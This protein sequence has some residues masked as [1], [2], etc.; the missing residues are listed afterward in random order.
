[1]SYTKPGKPVFFS[2]IR[3]QRFWAPPAGYLPAFCDGGLRFDSTP[4]TKKWDE[5]SAWVGGYYG[6]REEIDLGK[7]ARLLDPLPSGTLIIHDD[8]HH[9]L[10]ARKAGASFAR[11]IHAQLSFLQGAKACRTDLRY[12]VY[13]VPIVDY[14]NATNRTTAELSKANDQLAEL[15]AAADALT[16]PHYD[17]YA[18]ADGA[19]WITF[20]AAE[21]RRLA[22][23]R[24]VY[25]L[26][27]PTYHDGAEPALR[28]QPIPIDEWRD[29]SRRV[30]NAYDGAVLWG[31]D[32]VRDITQVRVLLEESVKAGNAQS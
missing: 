14:W 11:N 13:G 23:G 9:E 24:P 10:D 21:A 27:W 25:G 15:V 28:G 7:L 6:P 31:A 30:L 32:A 16:T 20:T 19:E 2:R 29:R 5:D 1:M 17:F 3:D 18:G 4:R 22:G 12:A 8:E 26:V